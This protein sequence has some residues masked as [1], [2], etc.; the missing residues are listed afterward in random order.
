MGRGAVLVGGGTG[1]TSLEVGTTSQ[2]MEAGPW[3]WSPCKHN[4]WY[5]IHKHLSSHLRIPRDTTVLLS[6]IQTD[7][8]ISF[9]FS[10]NNIT[11]YPT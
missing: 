5:S 3:T 6:H 10:H 8:Y 7:L 11:A 2:V 1:I 4:T 9:D